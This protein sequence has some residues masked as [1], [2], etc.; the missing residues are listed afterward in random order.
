[1]KSLESTLVRLQEF[2]KGHDISEINIPIGITFSAS[3]QILIKYSLSEP[4]IVYNLDEAILYINNILDN[5][6]FFSSKLSLDQ[7]LIISKE[8]AE[9]E[10]HM[11]NALNIIINHYSK[12]HK[13]KINNLI[14]QLH[15][16]MSG[17]LISEL[18]TILDKEYS[19]ITTYQ[20]HEKYG[21]IYGN[22]KDNLMFDYIINHLKL[23]IIFKKPFGNYDEH[24]TTYDLIS[25]LSIEYF[26]EKVTI[27][28]RDD[29]TLNLYPITGNL[30]QF[31][32]RLDLELQELKTND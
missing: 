17:N 19:Q 12:A 15:S 31:I 1:M 7:H 14:Q 2:I 27:D 32:N 23:E 25:D 20:Q 9:S 11:N 28:W 26:S 10:K 5:E 3:G 24:E 4:T 29:N 8:I 16:H 18:K 30:Q 6:S 13:I 21:N 22:M